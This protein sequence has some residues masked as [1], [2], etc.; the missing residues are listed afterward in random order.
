[1][2]RRALL[3]A[4]IMVL[5]FSFFQGSQSNANHIFGTYSASTRA[6]QRGYHWAARTNWAELWNTSSHCKT[7]ETGAYNR[8]RSSTVNTAQFSDRWYTGL[9]MFQYT[10]DSRVTRLVDIDLEYSDFCATHGCATRG[11]ENHRDTPGERYC[12]Y[13]GAH[14]PC[15]VHPSTVHINLPK[16]NDRSG[17]WRERL[18]MHETGHSNGLDEHCSSDAIMNDGT[19]SCNGG[20]WTEVMEYRATD[21][22]GFRSVYPGWRYN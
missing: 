13:W 21:R 1:M 16:W 14:Y 4:N 22:T 2:G 17:L 19:S 6:E 10:C 3:V 20:N 5:L 9:N 11:G 8:V 18:I 12:N 15:G 7:A